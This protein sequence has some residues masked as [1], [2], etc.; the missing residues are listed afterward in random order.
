MSDKT[1]TNA[2]IKQELWE[3]IEDHQTGMLGMSSEAAA[4]QPMTAFV[5]DGTDTLWFFT[6][7]D[8]DIAKLAGGGA[9]TF[10][11]IDRK[12]QATINGALSRSD[13]KARIDKFWNV[14]VAA[15]YPDGKDDPHLT[16]L[17]LDAHDTSVWLADGGLFKYIFEV[18]KANTTGATPDV[19]E[20]RN[21]AF[22]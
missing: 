3:A 14:H 18:A 8:T 2:E 9:A 11:F 22:R 16:L 4:L 21:I 12:I 20:R 10:V 6:R 7:A 1:L 19:G 5:E 15:W 13:D 17:R